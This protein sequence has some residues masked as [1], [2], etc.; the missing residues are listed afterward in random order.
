MTDASRELD[1]DYKLALGSLVIETSKLDS[2]L[3]DIIGSITGMDTAYAL[4]LVHHQQL[5]NKI[6]GLR[7]IFRLMYKGDDDPQY[8][9]IKEMLDG[10]KEVV[11]FRNSVVHALWHIDESGT[12][13]TVRFQARGKLTRSRQPAPIEK[14]RQCTREAVELGGNLS[15]LSQLYRVYTR[16]PA[17]SETPN[18]DESR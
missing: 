8:Q 1:N 18:P 7:A 11:D 4:I 2:K 3:T 17:R 14:I 5:S 6:D 16:S 12:P 9:P 15:A 13:H 10:I